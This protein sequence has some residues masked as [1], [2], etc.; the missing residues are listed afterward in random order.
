MKIKRSK[1][2][3][4]VL[5]IAMLLVTFWFSTRPLSEAQMI[6]KFH[7][8]KAQFEQLRLMMKEDNLASV[9]LEFA[10]AQPKQV[11]IDGGFTNEPMPLEV[12]ESRLALYRS[13]L[14]ALNF[15]WIHAR[16]TPNIVTLR[17]FGGGFMD[18]SWSIGYVWYQTPPKSLVKSAYHQMPYRDHTNVSRIEGDWYIYHSH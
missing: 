9:D 17:Q 3:V 14:K 6:A 12:S 15:D 5:A 13:R 16:Q 8:H 4:F 18:T 1:G 10:S 7:A 11:P 2:K